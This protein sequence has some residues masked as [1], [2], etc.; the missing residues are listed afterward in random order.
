MSEFLKFHCSEDNYIFT[1]EKILTLINLYQTY[2]KLVGREIKSI[3]KMW[4][5]IAQE[6]SNRYKI[7]VTSSKCENKFKVLE[8]Q[9][10]NVKDNNNKTGRGRRDFPYEDEFDKIFGKKLS[11]KPKILLTSSTVIL[12]EQNYISETITNTSDTNTTTPVTLSQSCNNTTFATTSRSQ[13]FSDQN[14]VHHIREQKKIN[15]RQVS[16]NYTKRNEILAELKNDMRTYQEKKLL[17]EEEKLKL[18]KER[19]EESKKRTRLL[20]LKFNPNCNHENQQI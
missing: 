6:F 14:T 10:K 7:T 11:I 13:T 3:K 18:K 17:L 2:K 15:K 12:P 8:R 9:Y 4:E 16:R 1:H 5:K 20:E 19:L